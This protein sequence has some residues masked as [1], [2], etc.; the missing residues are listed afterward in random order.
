MKNEIKTE[1]EIILG[2]VKQIYDYIEIEDKKIKH[3]LCKI[4]DYHGNLEEE[5]FYEMGIKNGYA[6]EYDKGE[7][8]AEGNYKD[9]KKDGEW[10]IKDFCHKDFKIL[11][12]DGTEEEILEIKEKIDGPLDEPYISQ[13][14]K[15]CK[16][17]GIFFSIAM[18]AITIACIFQ[19]NR[20]LKEDSLEKEKLRQGMQFIETFEEKEKESTFEFPKEY[21]PEKEEIEE[22]IL[23]FP[24]PYSEGKKN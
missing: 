20:F 14:I 12:K 24:K 7:I 15:R 22:V 5:C 3:G 11:F 21:K 16:R 13:H 9:G 1:R 10:K 4:Y 18:I 19:I 2:N 8:R 23:D 17:V 6:K